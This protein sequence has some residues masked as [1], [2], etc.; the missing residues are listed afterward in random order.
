VLHSA[1]RRIHTVARGFFSGHPYFVESPTSSVP[2]SGELVLAVVLA[3]VLL[4]SVC[5]SPSQLPHVI[6][7][8]LRRL[9]NLACPLCGLTRSFVAIGHG[10]WR[11]AWS[12]NPF[13]F[14]LYGLASAWLVVLLG[15]LYAPRGAAVFSKAPQLA[16]MTIV[17]VVALCLYGAARAAKGNQ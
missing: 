4:A 3:L 11:E 8:G 17:C 16:K 10:E 5:V 2:R 7:C 14:P 12:H 6:V 15:K 9:T 13:G 1:T